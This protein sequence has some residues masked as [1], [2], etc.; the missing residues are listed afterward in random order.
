M[1]TN[2]GDCVSMDKN[3]TVGQQFNGLD[4]QRCEIVLVLVAAYLEGGTIGADQP[5]SSLDESVSV[6]NQRTDLDDVTNIV[7]LQDS[8]C[9]SK[10]HS[11]VTLVQRAKRW[12]VPVR[13]E[14]FLPVI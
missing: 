6:A 9:L 2:N 11:R 1:R 8:R 14:R 7:I 12:V 10:I 3:V 5:L 13:R 4:R